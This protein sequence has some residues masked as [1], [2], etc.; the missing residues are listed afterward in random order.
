M[1]LRLLFPFLSKVL[2][3]CT[4]RSL[5]RNGFGCSGSLSLRCAVRQSQKQMGHAVVDA[6]HCFPPARKTSFPGC[7]RSASAVRWLFGDSKPPW[8]FQCEQFYAYDEISTERFRT[9]VVR[10]MYWR[11]PKTCAFR[12]R[13]LLG[14]CSSA[15]CLVLFVMSNLARPP[16]I[17]DRFAPPTQHQLHRSLFATHAP[18]WCR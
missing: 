12:S 16:A 14:S 5:L 11:R 8:T 10:C 6:V 13:A 4:P 18:P 1:F 7:P 9:M 2:W 3:F 17:R 15:C